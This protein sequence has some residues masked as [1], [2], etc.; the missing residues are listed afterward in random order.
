MFAKLFDE[1]SE[2]TMLKVSFRTGGLVKGVLDRVLDL[3]E[4]YRLF[5]EPL[6]M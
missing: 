1:L 4:K 6:Q 3:I 2:K 5:C